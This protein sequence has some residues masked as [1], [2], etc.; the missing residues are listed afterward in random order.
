MSSCVIIVVVVVVVF[1]VVVVIIVV[2]VVGGVAAA[3]NDIQGTRKI[4]KWFYGQSGKS[5]IQNL[6]PD[7]SG[8]K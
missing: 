8:E 1:I 6:N 2:V 4:F 7:E 5:R 3:L